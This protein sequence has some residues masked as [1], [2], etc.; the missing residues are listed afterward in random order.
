MEKLFNENVISFSEMGRINAG[1]STPTGGGSETLCSNQDC[2]EGQ[3]VS[4]S[5]DYI[6]S[7][8]GI[9]YSRG[10]NGQETTKFYA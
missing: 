7:F 4:W 10:Y 5:S 1:K 9:V 2:T 3:I 6:K 8:L